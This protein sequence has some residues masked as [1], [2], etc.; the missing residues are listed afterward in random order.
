MKTIDLKKQQV[1][2]DGRSHGLTGWDHFRKQ[3]PDLR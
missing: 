2:I 1:T 3:D